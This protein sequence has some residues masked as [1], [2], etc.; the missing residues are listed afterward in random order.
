MTAITQSEYR[1]RRAVSSD[2]RSDGLFVVAAWSLVGL[3]V[4]ILTIWLGLG[5]QIEPIMGLG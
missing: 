2:Q 1:S 5:G 3:T 4:T